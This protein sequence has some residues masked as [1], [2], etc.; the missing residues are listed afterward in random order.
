MKIY[1]LEPG[2]IYRVEGPAKVDVIDGEVYA[3][4]AL[5][6]AGQHFT[7]LRARRLAFKALS[8]SKVSVM[9]GPN[10]LLE[11]ARPEEE[12]LNEWEDA[13]SSLDLRG[14]TIVLGALDVGKSTMAVVL[15]N[16]ALMRGL[17]V[18]VIDADVGQNDLG[19]PTTISASRATKPI[20]SLRQMQAEKSIFMQSTSLERIW[21]RAVEA[22]RRLAEYARSSWRADAIIINT[23]GWVGDEE[24]V[25]YKRSLLSAIAPNNVVAIRME[26]ELDKITDGFPNV[27]FTRPPPAARARSKED[28]KIHRDMSYGRFI[29]PVKEI[30]IDLDKTFFCNL[31]LFKGVSINN[32]LINALSKTINIKILYANQIGQVVYAIV[33]GEWLIRRVGGVRILG[34]PENFERGL[35]VGFEDSDG[36][37]LGLG[38]IKRIYYEKRKAVVY[39]SAKLEKLL[40]RTKCIRLGFI[41]L[42]ESFEEAEKVWPLVKYDL[43]SHGKNSQVR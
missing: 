25:L 36:L 8:R 40:N 10:A 31:D 33:N 16:K 28:R 27:V 7:V 26:N 37:L 20:T 32:Q 43:N 21:G 5:Y 17:K 2:E 3:V 11:K 41:R 30:S 12:V 35:L 22:V 6:S 4:G 42:N 24:A 18:A 13:A 9:L 38:A 23:D 29:F 14:V 1:V 15:A 39:A 34:L 19:P